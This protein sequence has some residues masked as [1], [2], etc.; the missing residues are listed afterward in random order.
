MSVHDNTLSQEATDDLCAAIRQLKMKADESGIDTT[1]VAHVLKG[2][3]V[4]QGIFSDQDIAAMVENWIDIEGNQD[5]IFAEADEAIE[6][7]VLENDTG[8]FTIADD[9]GDNDEVDWMDI[10]DQPA[11]IPPPSFAQAEGYIDGLRRYMDAEQSPLETRAL[12]DRFAAELRKNRA[13]R[14]RCN[15]TLKCYFSVKKR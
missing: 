4:S 11:Q 2:S 13:S 5:V 6:E 8:N 12:L 1:S 3:F 10:D 9:N 15:P 14:S 7:Q